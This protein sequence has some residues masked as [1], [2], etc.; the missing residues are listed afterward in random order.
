MMADIKLCRVD[1]RLVHGQ[2]VTQWVKVCGA[3]RIVIIN[4]ALAGDDFMA[5]I[6]RMAVP[7]GVSVDVMTIEAACEGFAAD[8]L[9]DGRL[10]LLFKSVEDALAAIESGLA[11][12]DLQIGGLGGGAGT[13][14]A[15]GIA[16][17]PSDVE[18][19][20]TL[21]DKGVHIHLHVVPTQ[22]DVELPD[23]IGKLG[24]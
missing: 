13:K 21:G 24:F 19:M 18:A 2:V 3:N 15:Y 6:Y 10:L 11:I 9:G 4:D 17:R 16:F 7:P 23:L 8:G 12:N 5:D 14:T 22:A 20:K 1:F